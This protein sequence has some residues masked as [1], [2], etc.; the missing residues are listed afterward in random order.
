MR[1][2]KQQARKKPVHKRQRNQTTNIVKAALKTE[3]LRFTSEGCEF[4][5]KYF[6]YGR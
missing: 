5:L 3:F 4:H 1:V 6:Y 2:A